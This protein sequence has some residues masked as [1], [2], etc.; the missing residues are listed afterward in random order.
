MASVHAIKLFPQCSKYPYLKILIQKTYLKSQTLIIWHSKLDTC[1][2]SVPGR[3]R[4]FGVWEE[5]FIS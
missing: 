3:L 5:R 2:W 4:N 1:P